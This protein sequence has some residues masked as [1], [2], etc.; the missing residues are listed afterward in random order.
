MKFE[1]VLCPLCGSDEDRSVFQISSRRIVQCRGCGLIYRN[2]RPTAKDLASAYVQDSMDFL[3]EERVGGRR[4]QQ[5]R[6]F[7]DSFPDR[8]GHLLDVGCGSGF[9]LKM[10]Q[11]RGWHVV[12]VDPDAQAVAYAKAHHQVN[13][14]CSD[15]RDLSFPEGSFDLV[16]LW[17][18]LDHTPDPVD[19]LTRVHR[20]LKEKGYLF[21]RTPNAAWQYTS[22]RV[23]KFLRP[24]GWEKL[25]DR[26]P[27]SLFIF[28]LT[29]FSRTTLRLLLDHSGF[30]PLY[31]RN[32]PPIP[33]DPYLGLGPTGEQLVG[34]AKLAVHGTAQA[35]AILSGGRWLIGSSIEAWGQRGQ[36]HHR[37][38]RVRRAIATGKEP[39]ESVNAP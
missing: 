12:G 28:H 15:I 7:L 2:P 36:I 17:N 8:P 30:I 26:H 4:S 16:T 32:S 23:A 6:R 11:E 29:N 14:V 37:P 20:L 27:Y 21:I 34:L 35:V 19:V 3:G 25:F 24:L 38:V 5:F 9:F 22:F 33:G 1:V 10:A 13:A 31:I 39:E 18:V